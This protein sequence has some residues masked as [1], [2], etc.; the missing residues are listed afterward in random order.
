MIGNTNSDK[1]DQVIKRHL[2]LSTSTHF[3]D[4]RSGLYVPRRPHEGFDNL[5][6][7][8]N[9]RHNRVVV[10]IR[11]DWTLWFR[12]IAAVLG[13]CMSLLTL[14]LLVLTVFYAHKQWVEAHST[15]IASI[16]AAT[17]SARAADA[18]DA[19]EKQSEVNFRTDERAWIEL[20]ITK[21]S[22]IAVGPP[23]GNIFKYDMYPKNVGK[24]VARQVTVF[25]N[26]PSGGPEL[27][28]NQHG[29]LLFQ[30]QLF[31]DQ[32][33][34][35]RLVR[36]PSPYPAVIAPGDESS[37]PVHAIGHEPASHHDEVSFILGRIDYVDAF[38]FRHWKRFCYF[39]ADAQG[40]LENCKYGNDEDSM[41]ETTASNFE[42]R[43]RGISIKHAGRH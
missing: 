21:S 16:N 1:R 40:G 32:A 35:K 14:G 27:A 42:G 15:A 38:G 25:F 17:A 10:S 33:T 3:L 31:L 6:M 37:A 4:K 20:R 8:P 7:R 22:E 9:Q 18:A 39:V 24:T 30:D 28:K 43:Q 36:P 13:L 5:M 26:S 2:R 23:D 29:I 41:G 19:T 12:A 34:K 11:N